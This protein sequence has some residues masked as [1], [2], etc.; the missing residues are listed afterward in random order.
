MLSFT[1]YGRPQPQGS[2]RA[3]IPRGWR[4]AIITSTNPKLKSWRQE[5]VGAAQDAVFQSES[6]NWP[7]PA[8]VPV[9]VT[10][11]FYFKPPKKEKGTV[12]AT[13]PDL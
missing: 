8:G 13:R 7:I 3:F 5:L 10:L 11:R 2:T 6:G 12:K 9:R 1:V 4:R